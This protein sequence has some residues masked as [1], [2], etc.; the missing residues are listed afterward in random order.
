MYNNR[1]HN[2]DFYIKLNLMGS[3]IEGLLRCIKYIKDGVEGV[4]AE[5]HQWN[6][7]CVSHR[8]NGFEQKRYSR[9][10]DKKAGQEAAYKWSVEDM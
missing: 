8:S 10:A 1:D 9:I 5:F 2:F 6:L 3:F 7:I 4:I